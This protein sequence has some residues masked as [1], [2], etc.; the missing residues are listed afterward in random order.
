MSRE[1]PHNQGI[2]VG[3]VSG[4]NNKFKR[5]EITLTSELEV[6]DGI[7]FEGSRDSGTI[8]RGIYIGNRLEKESRQWGYYY[9]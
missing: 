9:Y 3:K 8:V 5:M 1:R 7:G 4:Y 6:G 2:V